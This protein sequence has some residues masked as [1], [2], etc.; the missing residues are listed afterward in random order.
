MALSPIRI[1]FIISGLRT[2]GAELML[3][4]L[5]VRLN[6]ARFSPQVISLLD[7]GSIGKRISS[8]DIP[9]FALELQ[10]PFSTLRGFY[11]LF[12]RIREFKPELI[13]G[14]MYHGNLAASLGRFI[15]WRGASVLWSIHHSLNNLRLEK[16]G[17]RLAIRLSAVLSR[18]ADAVHFVSENSLRQHS[19]LGFS[20]FNT[21]LLPNGVDT[22]AFAPDR[23]SGSE[24]RLSLGLDED[25]IVIGLIARFHPLKDH[26]NFLRAAALLIKERSG[27]NFVLAGS[28]VDLQN[29]GLRGMITS[30]GLWGHVHLLGERSDIAGILNG[31]D[32]ASLTSCGEAFP[33]SLCE[34]MACGVPCVTTDVGDASMLVGDTGVVVPPRN[35]EALAA[36]WL[37][38]IDMGQE[39]R[40]LLGMA[41][42]RRIEQDFSI[43]QIVRRYEELYEDIF[44]ENA[45]D[46][47]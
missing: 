43:E 27:V 22:Q 42:R 26:A 21:R 11:I 34:A 30:L 5:L 29:A 25:M 44:R 10:G 40:R 31:L 2:G 38:L 23:R 18:R 47:C 9:V 12:R 1:L 24:F 16:P 14:W 7:Q 3:Y 32:I 46:S 37:R 36:G 33:L 13:Q 6:R 39:A 8:L 17:T 45:D 20:E 4:T 28:H 19:R 35:A 41:A 15:A